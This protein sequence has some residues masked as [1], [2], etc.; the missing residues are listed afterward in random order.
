[1]ASLK[2]KTTYIWAGS[3]VGLTVI[4][5]AVFYFFHLQDNSVKTAGASLKGGQPALSNYILGS[6]SDPL[7]KPMDVTEYGKNVYVSDTNHQQIQ[8]FDS[9]GKLAFK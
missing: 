2:K 3:I 1:M 6:M 4:V 5:L 7:D 9:N 8:V